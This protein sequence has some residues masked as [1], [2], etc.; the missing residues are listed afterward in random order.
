[1]WLAVSGEA[2]TQIQLSQ[3]VEAQ[4]KD[5]FSKL[6]GVSDVLVAGE[7]RY[8]MRVWLHN[9]RLVAHGLTIA[10]VTG[11]LQRENVDIPSGR[12][13]G[14]DRE[15]TVRSLGELRTVEGYENLIV[16]TVG[17]RADPPAR[18]GDDRGRARGRAQARPLQPAAGDRP[19]H[20]QAVEGQHPRRGGRDP[21]RAAAG[22]RGA[23]AGR[24]ARARLRRGQVHP[25][26]DPRRPAHHLRGDRPGGAGDLP[27]PAQHAGDGDP[28]GRDPGLDRRRVRAALLPRLHDQHADADGRHPRDRPRGRRRHRR[29]RER[30]AP[31]SR[32]AA[33]PARRPS[34]AC[35]RSPS[36]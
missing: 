6:P 12:V 2:Y 10:D 32:K 17:E 13:E 28:R 14:V 8:A 7:R 15:Y 31:G 22:A 20:H 24:A 23:A 25:R 27:V 5:R 11:A 34:R 1:M 33:R 30:D 29:A 19:R 18:R 4:L 16:A 21:R 36:R 9:D 35:A 26:V 3:L